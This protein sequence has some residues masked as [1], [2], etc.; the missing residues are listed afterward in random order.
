VPFVDDKSA[1]TARKSSASGVEKRDW[2]FLANFMAPI[3]SPS[4]FLRRAISR[5]LISL[6]DSREG[7]TVAIL[8]GLIPLLMEGGGVLGRGVAISDLH[9]RSPCDVT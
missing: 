3:I 4:A 9:Q 2:D 7:S 8:L 1:R 6:A 5:A